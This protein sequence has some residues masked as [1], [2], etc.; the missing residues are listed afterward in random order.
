[1]SVTSDKSILS[2]AT[3]SATKRWF[4][5]VNESIAISRDRLIQLLNKLTTI[6]IVFG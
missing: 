3:Q 4:G 6:S 5:T 2:P 1:M